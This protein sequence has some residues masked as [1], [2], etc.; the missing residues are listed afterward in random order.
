MD[1]IRSQY[2]GLGCTAVL[3]TGIY[4]AAQ[5][6]TTEESKKMTRDFGISLI[7]LSVVLL[8]VRA[9]YLYP[10]VVFDP[11]S[12]RKPTFKG[13]SG[14]VRCESNPLDP[15]CTFK[16]SDL[17]I[18]EKFLASIGLEKLAQKNARARLLK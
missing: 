7:V 6:D 4:L 16:M 10:E 14:G 13:L 3:A 8:G 5:S 11:N 1:I 12:P 15:N 2:F 18:S 9:Y 17:S